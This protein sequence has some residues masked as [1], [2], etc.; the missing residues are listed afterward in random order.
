MPRKWSN[1]THIAGQV[2]Q[3]QQRGP[4]VQGG[5]HGKY[6]FSLVGRTGIW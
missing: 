3:A 6:H 4:Q 5:D 1:I 2:Q